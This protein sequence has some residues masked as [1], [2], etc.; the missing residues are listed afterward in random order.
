VIL[1]ESAN[2]WH[3]LLIEFC[4]DSHEVTAAGYQFAEFSLKAESRKR[5]AYA[6]PEPGQPPARSQAL[7]AA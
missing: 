1:S 7:G 2:G 5:G 3:L 4:V 6:Q